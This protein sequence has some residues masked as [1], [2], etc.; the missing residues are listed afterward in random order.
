[1]RVTNMGILQS[2]VPWHLELCKYN[3]C[4]PT[5]DGVYAVRTQKS[6][7]FDVVRLPDKC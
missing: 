6:I 1:M 4:M 7:N 5:I 3:L 2:M